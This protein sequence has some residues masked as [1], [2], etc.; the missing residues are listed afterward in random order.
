MQYFGNY[1]KINIF[2]LNKNKLGITICNLDLDF[3]INFNQINEIIKELCDNF[4]IE[5][6]D[7]IE[8]NKIISSNI[9]LICNIKNYILNENIID[10]ENNYLYYLN[11]KSKEITINLFNKYKIIILTIIG[12]MIKQIIELKYNIHFITHISKVKNIQD[13]IPNNNLQYHKLLYLQQEQIPI[14][15]PRAKILI[16]KE[17]KKAINNNLPISGSLETLIFNVPKGLGNP[18][19]NSFEAKLSEL[20]FLVPNLKGLEFANVININSNLSSPFKTIK[21]ENDELIYHSNYYYGIEEGITT[22][23]IISFTTHYLPPLV[24]KNTKSI[25][26]KTLENIIIEKN[27]EIINFYKNIKIIEALSSI[28]IYDFIRRKV[29]NE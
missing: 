3:E 5:Q 27:S 12:L 22:G 19:F 14:Y 26:Y 16:E 7:G 1:I 18:F 17:I 2:E 4:T 24:Y 8:N 13:I 20:L 23:D 9:T 21:F 6:I 10:P 28:V 29:I 25:N 15:D 11:N